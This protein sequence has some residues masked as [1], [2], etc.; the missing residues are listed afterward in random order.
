MHRCPH[1]GRRL[2]FG[3]LMAMNTSALATCS[4]CGGRYSWTAS[5][6]GLLVMFTIVFAGAWGLVHFAQMLSATGILL[7]I[8]G[9]IAISGLVAFGSMS[10]QAR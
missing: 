6:P 5:G 10:T 3:A 9:L 8:P 1:C 7:G 2:S 4:Q